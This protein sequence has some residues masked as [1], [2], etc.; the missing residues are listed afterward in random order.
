[1]VSEK[2]SQPLF[3]S[4]IRVFLL[5]NEPGDIQ[6]RMKGIVAAF[7]SS[8]TSSYQQLRLHTALPFLRHF[9]LYRQS[10]YFFLQQRLFFFAPTSILSI[11][12][13]SSLYHFP[14]FGTTDT[15]DMITSKTTQFPAP[16]SQKQSTTALD[17]IIGTNTYSEKETP[18]GLTARDRSAHTYIIGKSGMGK[19]TIITQMAY[20]DIVHGKG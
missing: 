8:T 16:L 10:L 19:T 1:M 5:Q 17:L 9:S 11:I 7:S 20:Q 2:I 14:Y 13:I 15:E 18:I 6:S 12:E 3:E 4:S